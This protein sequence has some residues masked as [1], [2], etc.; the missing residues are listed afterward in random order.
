MTPDDIQGLQQVLTEEFPV[1]QQHRCVHGLVKRKRMSEQEALAVY[2]D[3]EKGLCLLR[4]REGLRRLAGCNSTGVRF[5]RR[6]Q[7]HATCGVSSVAMVLASMSG[8]ILSDEE[9]LQ[10]EFF[11]VSKDTILKEGLTLAQLCDS[12]RMMGWDTAIVRPQ[13]AA[14]LQRLFAHS[15]DFFILNYDMSKAGQVPWGG[16]FAPVGGYHK[17]TA[18]VLLLDPWPYTE[19]VWIGLQKILTSMQ[20]VDRKSGEARGILRISMS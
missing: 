15:K 8:K 11:A 10:M 3:Y 9:M 18:S 14:E 19:P 5:Y 1:E 16:H 7:T 20:G 17:E 6:Q 2:R 13:S 4:S 12:C